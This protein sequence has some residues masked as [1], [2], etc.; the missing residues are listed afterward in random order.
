MTGRPLLAGERPGASR[1]PQRLT[2]RAA[3]QFLSH[4]INRGLSIDPRFAHE[5]TSGESPF[6]SGIAFPLR[7]C[8]IRIG[9]LGG[10]NRSDWV[11]QRRD[12][13]AMLGCSGLPASPILRTTWTCRLSH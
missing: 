11:T 13:T 8:Q 2:G 4:T 6:G 3:R 9:R 12:A 5:V 1:R 10:L 7:A